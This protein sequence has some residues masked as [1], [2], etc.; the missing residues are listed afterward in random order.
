V[1]NW[2]LMSGPMPTAV[3]CAIYL[4]CMKIIGPRIMRNRKPYDL[5]RVMVFYNLFQMLFNAWILSLVSEQHSTVN[6]AS[7]NC[8]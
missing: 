8:L 2:F 4:V 1:K 3:A 6:C 5:T 7:R